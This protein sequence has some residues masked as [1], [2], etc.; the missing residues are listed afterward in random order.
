[1]IRNLRILI[2]WIYLVG[3]SIMPPRQ[4]Y[5]K[6]ANR[7]RIPMELINSQWSLETFRNEKPSCSVFIN[8]YDKGRFTFTHQGQVFQGDHLYY[9][10]RDSTIQFH[11][12]P[13]DKLAWPEFNCQPKPDDFARQLSVAVNKFKITGNKLVLMANDSAYFVFIRE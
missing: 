1:M 12:R 8:F 11:T 4:Q 5:S 2:V 7:Q 3:C 6:E 13:L 9:I 10:V